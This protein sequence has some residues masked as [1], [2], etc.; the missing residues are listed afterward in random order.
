M[1]EG[2][3]SGGEIS[4]GK[5]WHVLEQQGQCGWK[6]VSKGKATQGFEGC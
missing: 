2:S 6:R 5:A 4:K 3:V 1:L